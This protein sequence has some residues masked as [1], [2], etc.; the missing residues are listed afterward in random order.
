M[1]SGNIG[2]TFWNK[3]ESHITRGLDLLGIRQYDQDQELKWVSG[4][5]TI[6]YRA[7]YFPILPWF[8]VEYYN[9]YLLQDKANTEFDSAHFYICLRNLEFIILAASRFGNQWGESGN[10]FGVLGSINFSHDLDNFKKQG[11]IL[12][13]F[14]KGGDT[15]NTYL[16]PCRSFGLLGDS[17]SDIREII[18]IPPRGN[19]LYDIKSKQLNHCSFIDKIFKNG[20]ISIDELYEYG[21]FFSVNGLHSA[22][23]S[24]EREWLLKCFTESYSD[25]VNDTYDRFNS[26]IFLAYEL[27]SDIGDLSSQGL[28]RANYLRFIDTKYS[29]VLESQR[30]WYEYELQRLIHYA[31][32]LI[33]ADFSETVA[34]NSGISRDEVINFWKHGHI[35]TFVHEIVNLD[36]IYDPSIT[37]NTLFDSTNKNFIS[38]NFQYNK[39]ASLPPPN[40]VFLAL[41][42]ILSCYDGVKKI[43]VEGYE[44]DHLEYTNEIISIIENNQK[45]KIWDLIEQFCF[46][47][48]V[49]RH[50]SNS[51]RKVSQGLKISMR[52]Y[53]EGS[54][55]L[56][57]GLPVYPWY[58]GDRLSNVLRIMA[59]LGQLDLNEQ[60]FN[61]IKHDKLST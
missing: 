5:T 50:F 39:I 11:N 10:T 58:S 28:I 43:Q 26:S 54:K 38:D 41:A 3:G 47:T 22:D 1:N 20:T 49:E 4:I 31:S 18:E 14:K 36:P 34:M 15:L 45:T 30:G 27:L 32:E 7:R 29:E 12:L 8:L 35:V 21:K 53:M 59:D 24:S 17:I 57:T 37:I 56:S 46:S 60:K 2:L 48:I 33:L 23:N 25:Q 19:E 42:I 16:N 55:Y 6:S 44:I 51:W 13:S 52:F 61:Y 9:R 40:K